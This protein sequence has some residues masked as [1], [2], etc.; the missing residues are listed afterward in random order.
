MHANSLHDSM[1][2]PIRIFSVPSSLRY[3]LPLHPLN[4]QEYCLTI[5]PN[6]FLPSPRKQESRN[7]VPHSLNLPSFTLHSAS[8]TFSRISAPHLLPFN[9]VLPLIPHYRH[10]H[11]QRQIV[12]YP[13]QMQNVH[14][15][16]SNSSS[17]Q[18]RCGDNERDMGE[19][20]S[21]CLEEQHINLIP[22]LNSSVA[23]SDEMRCWYDTSRRPTTGGGRCHQWKSCSQTQRTECVS[24]QATKLGASIW[25]LFAPL[26]TQV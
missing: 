21:T 12:A 5:W 4:S 3:S 7:R 9:P 16:M 2:H 20:C 19:R 8:S 15:G 13:I 24:P 22:R 14:S 17:I 10:Q 26:Q 6:S 18:L 23:A 11:V 1:A 25:D